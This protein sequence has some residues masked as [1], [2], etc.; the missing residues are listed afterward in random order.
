MVREPAD[1]LAVLEVEG[2]DCHYPDTG[3]GIEHISLRLP[4]G[5]FTV[6]TGRIGSG[7]TTLLRAVLGLLPIESGTIRWNGQN[8]DDPASFF[9]PPRSAYTP[10]VPRLFSDS[11]RDNLLLGLPDD[12]AALRGALHQAVMEDDLAGMG[13]GLETR[14][15]PR[16]VRLSGGQAQRTAAARMFIR[17]PALLVLDD[18]SS[19]LDVETERVLWERLAEGWTTDDRPPT[20][21]IGRK[22]EDEGRTVAIQEGSPF[23][24][25]PLSGQVPPTCLVVS[26]RR[27]ALRRADNI[28]VLKDGRVVG[29]GKLDELLETCDEMRA[30]W[31]RDE[32]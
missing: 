27:A 29:E 7:K 8:V 28:L 2:L 21:Q 22:T 15:G 1:D 25:R 30:L 13:G 19:A 31:E 4:R 11:L 9:V 12:E 10:Q 17:R 18:V 23:V 5:S 26:H 3:R 14:V 16:G 24:V 20:T 6:V 32:G